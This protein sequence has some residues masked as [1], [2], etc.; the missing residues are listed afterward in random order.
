MGNANTYDGK[1]IKED[2]LTADGEI[3]SVICLS[4]FSDEISCYVRAQLLGEGGVLMTQ[5]FIC[6]DGNMERLINI[7]PVKKPTTKAE[8]KKKNFDDTR[9]GVIV[10]KLRGTI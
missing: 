4:D 8:I 7:V 2:K 6:D 1:I 3:E 5:P 10:N 9:L